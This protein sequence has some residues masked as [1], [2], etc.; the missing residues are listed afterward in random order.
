MVKNEDYWRGAEY[1][2][3]DEIVFNFIPDDNTRLNAIK[4][5]DYHIGEVLPVQ[6]A[7]NG[8]QSEWQGLAD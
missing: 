4:T 1:P 2:M 3:M 8:R 6:V 7:G 5:G